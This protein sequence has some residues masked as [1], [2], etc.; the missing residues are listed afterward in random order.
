MLAPGGVL[1]VSSSNPDWP[2]FVPGALT[3]HY[4]T[5]PV[6]HLAAGSRLAGSETLRAFALSQVDSRQAAALQL[7]RLVL[8]SRMQR[9]ISR[10]P[11]TGRPLPGASSSS[12]S[13]CRQMYWKQ[14]KRSALTCCRPISPT[15]WMI[16]ALGHA[17]G[18]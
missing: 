11:T 5:A 10:I 3:S 17:P 7:R 16:Y 13:N 6:G 1:L 14:W 4:P 12:P 15:R 9:V 8:Q 2:H 18:D